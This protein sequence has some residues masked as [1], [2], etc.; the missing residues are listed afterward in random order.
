MTPI[1]QLILGLI[2]SLPQEIA[3]IQAVY[4]TIRDALA[5]KD[6]ATLDAIFAA[7]NTKTDADV[8]QLDADAAAHGG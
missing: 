3:A 4:T 5:A 1:I 8:A 6:Q 7:T 2:A